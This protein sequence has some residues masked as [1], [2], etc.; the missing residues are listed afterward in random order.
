[1]LLSE[2]K[3][4]KNH[5]GFFPLSIFFREKEEVKLSPPFWARP[6]GNLKALYTVPTMYFA[7]KL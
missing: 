6:A 3:T 5:T 4:G 7:S 1:M 2:E